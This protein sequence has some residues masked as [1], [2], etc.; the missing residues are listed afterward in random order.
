MMEE[1]RLLKRLCKNNRRNLQDN[2]HCVHSEGEGASSTERGTDRVFFS[3]SDATKTYLNIEYPPLDDLGASMLLITGKT[4]ETLPQPVAKRFVSPEENNL[5]D[6]TI[7]G[8]L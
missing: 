5:E 2:L 4:L 6:L 1:R 3:S 7:E 8:I